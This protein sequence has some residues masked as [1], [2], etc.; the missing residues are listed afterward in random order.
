M[1]VLKRN[2]KEEEVH[3]DKITNRIKHLCNNLN[4]DFVNPIKVTQR[5]VE[6]VYPGVTT[7]E[8]DTLAA[9]TCAYM[10]QYHPDFSILAA[11]I[12]ISN[13]HKNTNSSFLETVNT[14]FYIKDRTGRSSPL[15]SNELFEIVSKNPK[16]FEE[17][18]DY[19]KDFEYDYFGFKT[20]ERSYLLKSPIDKKIIERP[21][22]MLMRVCIGIH[23]N[24]FEAVKISYKLMSSGK[25]T[26]ATP[27]LFNAGTQKPQMSSC[28][29]L[30]MKDDSINGIFETL[31][32]CALIS[33]TAGGI[34]I[35][36]SNIRSTES[37]IRGTNGFSN[38][39]VPMLRVF[40][41]T[42]RYVDQG[43]GKRKGS[44]AVYLEP[45]HSDIFEFLDLKK[46]HGK[47]EIRARDLFYG[48][49]IPDIFMRRVMNNENWTLFCPNEAIGLLDTFGEEFEKLYLKYESELNLGKRT[50]KAQ[51]LWFKILEA[52]QE[53]GTPYMLY[54]DACN[55]KSNQKNLGVI[56]ASNLCT[57][58]IE[59]TSPEEVHIYI[60][61]NTLQKYIYLHALSLPPALS[62]PLSPL[63]LSTPHTLPLPPLSQPP[64]PFQPPQ[65]SQFQY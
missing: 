3:F 65:P 2:G 36:I 14:L 51:N 62:L 26:H 6:G 55:S 40:N 33:K 15:V 18:I 22:H 53:T 30:T 35:S 32:Q 12:A 64:Q 4:P 7:S 48:L 45:W 25:F 27:T 10:S 1:Y 54:K 63:T 39:I 28:F 61:T 24:D 52:Q 50:V 20:L 11:R 9:E 47:E 16:Q 60:H 49:W 43:G 31:K 5:V 58:I 42:A 19:S 13:L 38:G 21:Q 46:N 59:Y 37:Y 41:D 23:A 29:L 56:R 8:L 34:G 17:L 57:E 44:I